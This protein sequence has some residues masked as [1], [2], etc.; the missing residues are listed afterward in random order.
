MD[1]EVHI[2]H[3]NKA[4]VHMHLRA[5]HF[6]NCLR[7]AYLAEETSATPNT[8]RLKKLVNLT[9]YLWQQGEIPTDLDW[10]I[11]VLMLKEKTDTWG[12][13]LDRDP[14]E[15]AVGYHRHSPNGVHHLP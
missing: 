13:Q 6:K 9:Q 7:E 11:L 2:L 5:E 15:G 3:W 12:G 10:T 1:T 14:L 4:C 8:E